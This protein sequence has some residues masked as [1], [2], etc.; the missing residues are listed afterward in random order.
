MSDKKFVKIGICFFS[1][2]LFILVSTPLYLYYRITNSD[3]DLCLDTGYC[4][5]GIEIST[6]YGKIRINKQTCN[7]NNF[8]WIEEDK[9]CLIK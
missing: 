2:L 1:I 6:Q 7:E 5:E 9:S 4:S 3:I 8:R